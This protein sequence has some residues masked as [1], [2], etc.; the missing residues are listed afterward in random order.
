MQTTNLVS[1]TDI[2]KLQLCFTDMALTDYSHIV[3][4]MNASFVEPSF[5]THSRH[6]PSVRHERGAREREQ[7]KGS[8]TWVVIFS[9]QR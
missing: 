6:F 3:M 4:A 7:T 5:V 8:R 1:S 9:E 2:I